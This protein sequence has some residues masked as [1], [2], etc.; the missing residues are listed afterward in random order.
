MV[1]LKKIFSVLVWYSILYY[2]F[3]LP[4]SWNTDSCICSSTGS[5]SNLFPG[6]TYNF[7]FNLILGPEKR[8]C[9]SR[10]IS[11]CC[12][13]RPYRF[14]YQ[15]VCDLLRLGLLFHLC[16][17]GALPYSGTGWGLWVK[18]FH[19]IFI[20]ITALLNSGLYEV[21]SFLALHLD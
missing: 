15:F 20:A 6:V 7:A 5:H 14:L 12:Q 19:P 4:S 11:Y 2:F 13:Q 18:F 16:M 9:P 3:T 8:K 1:F 10:V 17:F 21:E